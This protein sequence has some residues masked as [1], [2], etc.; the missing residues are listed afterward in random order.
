MDDWKST[1][2]IGVNTCGFYGNG[3]LIFT[4]ECRQTKD[5]S[6][7]Y[8]QVPPANGSTDCKLVD[9]SSGSCCPDL[10]KPSIYKLFIIA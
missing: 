2:E 6:L 5:C 7:W 1:S 8:G 9:G 4:T 10:R 3:S